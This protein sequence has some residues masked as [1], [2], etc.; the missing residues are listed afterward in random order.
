MSILFWFYLYI[1]FIAVQTIETSLRYDSRNFGRLDYPECKYMWKLRFRELKMVAEPENGLFDRK[2]KQSKVMD[3]YPC[4]SWQHFIREHYG[5]KFAL[6]LW[7]WAKSVMINIQNEKFWSWVHALW[8]RSQF[9]SDT[10]Y[11]KCIAIFHSDLAIKL[12]TSP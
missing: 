9:Y 4:P 5:P 2:M 1:L 11:I 7:F 10:G 8:K 12:G 6:W 3:P